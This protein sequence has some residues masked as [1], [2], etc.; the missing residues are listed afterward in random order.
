MTKREFF[1]ETRTLF[2]VVFFTI[3]YGASVIW[4]L[5]AAVEPLYTGGI[6]GLAQ[7]VRNMFIEW[8]G[9]DF[10]NIFLGLFVLVVNIPIMVLGWFGVSKRFTVYSLVSVLIQ[11]TML[12]IIPRINFGIQDTFT[13]A[14]MGGL[15]SGIGIGGALKY[16]TSTGGLDIVAQYLS[17]KKGLSVGYV[18]LILN[19]AIAL[20]GSVVSGS[21]AIA[22]YTIIRIIVTTIV[23]DK[24]HTSYNVLKVQIITSKPDAIYELILKDIYRG[25]TILPAKGAYSKDEKSLLMVVISA[26]EL[27]SLKRLIQNVDNQAFVIVEPVRHVYGNFAKKTIV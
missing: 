20:M 25:V 9:I 12:G 15:L 26:Y 27:T 13:L 17:L 18:S 6:P 5:E 7:L 1:Q 11:S 19:V 2:A 21:W 10:G 3:L 16:G 24:I 23:T 4:F 8:A 22:A 14:V